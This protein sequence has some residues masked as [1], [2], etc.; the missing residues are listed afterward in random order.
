MTTR[1]MLKPRERN[2]RSR[3]PTMVTPE[4]SARLGERLKHL[5][6]DELRALERVK[7]RPGTVR[8]RVPKKKR[9]T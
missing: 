5:S 9:G 8:R 3:V 4:E 6:I 2:W 1:P 7:K